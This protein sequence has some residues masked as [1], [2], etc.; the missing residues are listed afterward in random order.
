[1]RVKAAIGR[2]T[3]VILIDSGSTH[4]FVDH[5]IAH[6]LQLAVAP[7]EEFTVKVTNGE[8]LRCTKR[9]VNVIISIQGFH[10]CT[11]LYSLP[12]HGIDIVLGI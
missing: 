5:K 10:F 8:K 9:Y 2:R 3:L 6:T 7:T 11:T 1:M 4:N 12:L